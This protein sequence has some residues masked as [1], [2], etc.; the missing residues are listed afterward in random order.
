[1]TYS[2]DWGY[3]YN[4]IESYI[5]DCGA[6]KTGSSYELPDCFI[7]LEALPPRSVGR[8]SFPHTRVVIDGPGAEEFYHAFFLHFLSGGA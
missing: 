6:V 7:R 3:T 1:M 4:Q 5:L 8:L 2:G